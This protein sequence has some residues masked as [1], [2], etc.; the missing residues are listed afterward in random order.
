MKP[1]YWL[2]LLFGAGLALATFSC[3][4]S[5]TKPAPT[6]GLLPTAME[7]CWIGVLDQGATRVI[8][9]NHSLC[10]KKSSP[11]FQLMGNHAEV[12]ITPSTA[13]WETFW[14]RMDQVKVW[15]WQQRY[16]NPHVEDGSVWTVKLV[17]G[18][19]RISVYGRNSY[20]RDEDVRKEQ[21]SSGQVYQAY[22]KAVEEL[23]GRPLWEPDER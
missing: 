14:R 15:D 4:H 12:T 17:H 11:W 8:W 20:P 19:Q 10:L 2:P 1:V 22:I 7:L 9:T 21:S 5:P 13:A 16:V 3:R 6:E 23:L 18:D